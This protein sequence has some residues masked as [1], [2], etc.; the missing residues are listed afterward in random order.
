M[1]DLSQVHSILYIIIISLTVG[2]RFPGVVLYRKYTYEQ[3]ENMR[4][5]VKKIHFPKFNYHIY[6]IDCC[7][8]I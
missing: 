2:I 4:V 6:I 7:S 5:I 8:Y 3:Q 1:T